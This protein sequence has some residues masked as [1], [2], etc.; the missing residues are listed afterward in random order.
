MI[1]CS[2]V[3]S[4]AYGYITSGSTAHNEAEYT[5]PPVGSL[6][7]GLLWKS[8][9]KEALCLVYAPSAGYLTAA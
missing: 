1:Y 7:Y 4:V 3:P 9:G 8:I 5:F 6:G 2:R